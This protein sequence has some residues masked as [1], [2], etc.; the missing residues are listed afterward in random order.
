[1]P[2][3]LFDFTSMY[4]TVGGL[5]DLHRF[6][7]SER[8]VVEEINPEEVGTMY[9][10]LTLD[11]CFEP[12]FWQ[13]LSGFALVAPNQDILP[14]RAAYNG[15]T[16]GIGMN[17]I[18]SDEPLWYTLADC[19]ASALLTGRGVKVLRVVML[20]PEG[21]SVP[22]QSVRLRGAVELDPTERDPMLSIVEE[23]QRVKRDDVLSELEKKRRGTALKVVGSSGSYGVYSEFNA[24]TARKGE[25]TKVNVFGRKE[26]FFDQVAAPEDPGR[27]CF[28]PFASWITGG[29]RL[30]LAMLERCVTDLGGTW[31]FCDTDSMAIVASPDGGLV[32]CPGGPLRL[33]D[34]RE[35]VLA[36]SYDEV[37]AIQARF[38]A[39]SPYDP[40]LVPNLLKLEAEGLCYSI[41]A[42]RYAIYTLDDDGEPVF[43]PDHPPSEHGLGHFLNPT[44]P[45]SS[46]RAWITELWRIIIRRVHGR[47]T[48]P[49]R[50]LG[51]ATMIRTTVTS[52]TVRRAFRRLNKGRRYADQIKPFNFLLSAAG[53]KPPAG[54]PAGRRFRLIAPYESDPAK[55]EKRKWIDVHHPEAGTH[56]I[57][58]RDGR[59]GLARVDTFADVLAKYETHPESKALGADAEPFG[60]GTVGLLRRRPVTVGTITLIGKESNRIEERSSGEMTVEDVDELVTTYKDHDEWYRI[61]LSRLREQGAST[62]AKAA[63]ISTRRAKDLLMGRALPHP[64]HR[65]VL[66][67]LARGQPTI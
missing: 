6:Q 60:R 40:T 41:S 23:R 63:D 64:R 50:W 24:R 12:K 11:E 14:V 32:A 2:V 37:E 25:T 26:S 38:N 22:T 49:P 17:P 56:S 18:T 51:R 9:E 59:P 36:L 34:G 45:E 44:D 19:A 55:W 7:L 5:M 13:T 31:V 61:V 29:A 48:P 28:P 27:Y 8:I 47:E 43:D 33:P 53:A 65:L 20:R 1:M 10:S 30:M 3:R 4:P 35:A 54:R 57:T 16:W 15:K 46:D 62:V 67:E 66:E 21:E 52:S 42:K 58:T 39:L